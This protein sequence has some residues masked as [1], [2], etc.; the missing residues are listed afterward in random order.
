MA[1]GK[2][3]KS[4]RNDNPVGRFS[5]LP[6]EILTS[7]AYCSLTPNARA[8]LDQLIAMENGQNNG[9]LWLSV[10]DAAARIGL[11]NRDSANKAFAELEG[12]GLIA[13]TKE[14]HFAVKA[15]DTSRARCWRLTFLHWTGVGARTDEW[16]QFQP[17]DKAAARRMDMGLAAHSAYR[18]AMAQEKMPVL[19]SRTMKA[20][21]AKLQVEPVHKSR[22]AKPDNDA[23]PP[24][25]VVH[26][27]RTHTAVTMGDGS[28]TICWRVGKRLHVLPG[29]LPT[30]SRDGRA[31][32]ALAA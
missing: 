1:K 8:L 29:V 13:M 15:S 16:R 28:E 10:R 25:L 26:D 27:L 6:H 4:G 20:S 21:L 14:A 31:N 23:K 17:A 22:T 19:N 7:P 9:S 24:K 2:P 32:R 3:N 12:A 30:L 11:C 5:R 18:K